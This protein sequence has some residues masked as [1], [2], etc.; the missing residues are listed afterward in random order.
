MTAPPRDHGGNLDAAIHRYGGSRSDW[1]DLS[2]G[3]N[4]VPYPVG[5][6]PADAWTALPD[7]AA[8]DRLLRAARHVWSV[9]KSAGIIIAPGASALIA[10]MPDL[11]DLAGAHIPGPTYNEHAAAFAK[12]GHHVNDPDGSGAFA[13]IYVHPNNPDGRLWEAQDLGRRALT[14][15]DE[16]FCDTVPHLSHI[17]LTREDGIVLLKSFGK[18]WGLAGL[19]LG[20]AIGAPETL[21]PAI[22]TD[23]SKKTPGRSLTDLLGPWPVS[24]PALE[25]GARALEDHDWA[26]ATRTRLAQDAV[27]LDALLTGGGAKVAGG[28]TLFRL[29]EVDD[30]TTWQHR[31]AEHHIW[32]RI[33]PYSKTWLRLGL[34][35]S[36]RWDQLQAALR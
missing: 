3:I 23:S 17:D 35:A 4:P 5:D 25:I 8:T 7:Q 33:F 12:T 20:F 29:Y 26:K 10:R 32:S 34:P 9:P 28:T 18:F 6:I 31:L 22:I 1:L 13:D 27:R 14:I 21:D 11:I 24:G 2:T 15:I 16:S 36:D 19:R 30:A